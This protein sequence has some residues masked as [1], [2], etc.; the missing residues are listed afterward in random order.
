MVHKYSCHCV[1]NVPAQEDT[2]NE[3][4]L[5]GNY[6]DRVK[7]NSMFNGISV[8][9]NINWECNMPTKKIDTSN[10]AYQPPKLRII[11]LAAEEVLGTGCKDQNP[12]NQLAGLL[13]QNTICALKFCNNLGS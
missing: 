13:I 12:P 6:F 5:T 3:S 10:P 2:G 7:Q 4:A 1:P 9:L 11:E 8:N